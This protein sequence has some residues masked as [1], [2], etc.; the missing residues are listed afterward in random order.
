MKHHVW[1]IIATPIRR[2]IEINFLYRL[3][4]HK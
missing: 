3:Q 2:L 1:Q 4:Q